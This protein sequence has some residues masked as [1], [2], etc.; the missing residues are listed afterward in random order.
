MPPRNLHV[1]STGNGVISIEWNYPES[2]GGSPIIKYII[3]VCDVVSTTYKR[4]GE[5][6]GLL[7]AYDITNLTEGSKYYVRVM[8]VNEA[9]SSKG[10]AEL[11]TPVAARLP[12]SKDQF[13]TTITVIVDYLTHLNHNDHTQQVMQKS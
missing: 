5:V 12:P 3:E 10:A 2:D 6:D 7:L 9:G 13:E 1:I 11:S 8:S 4:V